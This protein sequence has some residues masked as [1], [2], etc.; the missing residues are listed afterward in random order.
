M[1]K[2]RIELRYYDDPNLKDLKNSKAMEM[3][4]TK[5]KVVSILALIRRQNMIE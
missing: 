3:I 5:F 2:V 4:L 1:E